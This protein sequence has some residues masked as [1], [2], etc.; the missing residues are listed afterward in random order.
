VTVKKAAVGKVR[1]GGKERDRTRSDQTEREERR[2]RKE[3]ERR[4]AV[5]LMSMEEERFLYSSST[6]LSD[7]PGQDEAVV[8]G[9][10][11]GVL[12]A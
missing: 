8:C 7:P 3:M 6:C 9:K 5:V 1:R 4:Q 12:V 11:P 10:A 2:R